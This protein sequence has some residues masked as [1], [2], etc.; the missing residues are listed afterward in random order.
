[1]LRNLPVS[2]S[3]KPRLSFGHRALVPAQEYNLGVNTQWN[4][5]S[6]KVLEVSVIQILPAEYQKLQE[7]YNCSVQ[8]IRPPR[9]N[10]PV[11]FNKAQSNFK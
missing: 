11:E 9:S 3:R 2:Q 7:C 6:I 5:S 4:Q 1:M 10:S 8:H